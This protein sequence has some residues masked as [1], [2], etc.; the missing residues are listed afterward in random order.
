MSMLP[1][2][3]RSVLAVLCLSLPAAAQ[4]VLHVVDDLAGPGV[5][6][7]DVQSAVDAASDGDTILVRDGTYPGFTVTAKALAVVG[8]AGASVRFTSLITVQNLGGNDDVVLRG[9][10]IEPDGLLSG[11]LDV[12]TST[13]SLWVEDIDA[14]AGAMFQAG[15][16]A[17]VRCDLATTKPA[18]G[19]RSF[20]SD[21]F[22][23]E[24]TV[25]AGP[26]NDGFIDDKLGVPFPGGIG[27]VGLR[28]DGGDELFVTG[29]SLTGGGGGHG[30]EPSPPDP[31]T[32]GGN[33]GH[34]LGIFAA[35]S[36][37]RT[38]DSV[39][40]GG[41]GGA[42]GAGC[43]DGTDGAEVFVAAGPGP[44]SIAGTTRS[45]SGNSPVREGQTLTL[46]LTGAPD[47]VAFLLYSV[48]Q[49]HAFVPGF[50]GALLLASP[51][52]V[53]PSSLPLGPAGALDLPVTVPELG[54]G[55]EALTIHLAAL[56]FPTGGGK[57]MGSSTA[58][59]LL[60]GSF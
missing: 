17:W 29:S 57:I 54:A 51:F 25:V 30:L 14:E 44:V 58:V 8:D 10:R 41:L 9:F 26:G 22:I 11:L 27:G 28:A 34:G 31:C 19:L 45:L 36:L 53:V 23:E 32:N 37:V 50:N 60:D 2:A 56:H 43:A 48:G 40:T 1:R 55:I 5:D 38:Q 24:C 21:A 12:R 4:G 18:T 20:Q 33:G 59:T 47:D 15:S 42:G 39:F 16:V 46:S 35:S 49:E 52:T 3:A 7:T 6:F 13:G